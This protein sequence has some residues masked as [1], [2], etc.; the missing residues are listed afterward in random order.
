VSGIEVRIKRWIVGHFGT[1]EEIRIFKGIE[2][3]SPNNYANLE[4]EWSHLDSWHIYGNVFDKWGFNEITPA[5]INSN[6]F[7]VLLRA[8][9]EAKF[10]VGYVHV[11]VLF[12]VI[13]TLIVWTIPNT[14]S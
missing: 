5:D 1:D 3:I 4:H 8:K 2:D 14:L 11:A 9:G 10:H 6:T 7:G 13:G 12:E